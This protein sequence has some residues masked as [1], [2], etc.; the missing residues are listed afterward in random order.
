M[1]TLLAVFL[2]TAAVA[3]AGAAVLQPSPLTPTADAL[4]VGTDTPRAN[5]DVVNGWNVCDY[6]VANLRDAYLRDADLLGEPVSGFDSHIQRFRFGAL[7]Y[8]PANPADWKVEVANLGLADLKANGMLPNYGAELHPAVRDW[9]LLQ[10]DNGLDTPRTIGRV[11]SAP[12]CDATRCRQWTEK[13]LF[14]F[15][16]QA[17]AATQVQ[18]APLGMWSNPVPPPTA[19]PLPILPIGAGVALVGG[20]ALLVTRRRQPTS[21][22]TI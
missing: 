10:G 12:V 16:P 1:K 14:I 7:T 9:L 8:N 2:L 13:Q 19:N 18:R 3:A 6:G 21:G 17:T 15:P 4:P 5:C 11:I 22:I 20:C